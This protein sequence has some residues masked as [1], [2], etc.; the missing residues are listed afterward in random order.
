MRLQQTDFQ[1]RK[2]NLKLVII[3]GVLAF[4]ISVA[5]TMFFTGTFSRNNGQPNT[6]EVAQIKDEAS[7]NEP[8]QLSQTTGPQKGNNLNQTEPN[9]ND[10][11]NMDSEKDNEQNDSDNLELAYEEPKIDSKKNS[12]DTKE[13]ETKYE[14]L[15]KVYSSMKAE[16]AAIV[17]CELEPNLTEKILSKMSERVAGKIMGAIVDKDP[18]YA[19]QVSKLLVNADNI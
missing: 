17:M 1:E 11:A 6:D 3:M 15:A 12:K 2:A 5:A 4:I 18:S 10:T 16:N 14:Q 19:A 9:K 8:Q 13:I 7:K